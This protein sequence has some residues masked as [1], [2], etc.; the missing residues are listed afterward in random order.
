MGLLGCLT[1][2]SS[3]GARCGAAV[4]YK[5]ENE[6]EREKQGRPVEI[7]A[8]VADELGTLL[9]LWDLRLLSGSTLTHIVLGGHNG[10]L[11]LPG[12]AAR[13]QRD[14]RV[15]TCPHTEKTWDASDWQHSREVAVLS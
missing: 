1:F 14:S 10:A 8:S 11:G 6:T 5:R 9:G 15:D 4:L 13:V 3:G 2:F 12:A 7:L